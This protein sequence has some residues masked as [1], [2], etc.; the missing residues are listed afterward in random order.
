MTMWRTLSGIGALCGTVVVLASVSGCS[1]RPE[2]L[3]SV[4]GGVDDGYS[5]G[6]EF[7]S[8][9]NL[10]TG[11]DVVMDSKRIGEVEYV[12][13]GDRAV[14]VLATVEGSAHVP[15]DVQAIIRQDTLLGDTYVALVRDPNTPAHS[16]LG[17]G[18]TVSLDRTTSPPQLEDTMAVL[19]TFINGGTIYRVEDMMRKANTVMPPHGDI[20]SLASV[21]STD[22]RDLSSRTDEIDRMI[23]GLDGTSRA[24]QANETELSTVFDSSAVHYWNSVSENIYAHIGSLLPSI[25]SVFEGGVW[26]A[27]MLDSL[28]DTT[29]VSLSGAPNS[30]VEIVRFVEE[31]LLP[32]LE[33]PSVDIV[34]VQDSEG[35][36]VLPDVAHLLTM[37]GA[38]R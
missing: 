6:I 17:D 38:T 26:M 13:V 24:V 31:T 2:D 29:D 5:I 28:A 33:N 8:V 25:G 36:D 11:A 3:P 19:A 15:T 23:D 27:P 9:A 35:R 16:W 7:D 4:R 30:I 34:S 22:L 21:V 20:R 14:T 1:L 32:Y 10:P 18:D 12:E 37:L